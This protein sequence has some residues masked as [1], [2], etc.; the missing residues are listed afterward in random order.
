MQPTTIFHYGEDH[1]T[2]GIALGICQ[3]KING[4]LSEASRKK[5]KA[6][7]EI[8]E[9]IVAQ[10]APV[11]GINTGIGSLCTTMISE[12][13]TRLLQQNVLKSHSVGVGEAIPDE[14]AKLMLVLKVQALAKGFSGVA[15]AT[16]DRILWHIEKDVIP[17]VPSQGSVGASGDLAP[18]SHLFL[19][20]IGLGE[21][22][23]QGKVRPTAE[24]LQK[25]GLEAIELGPKE[26]L[27][28]ING[29]QFIAAFAVKVVQRLHNC[30]SHADLIGALMIEGLL[31]S[32]KPFVPELHQLRPYKG[33]ST[34]CG[35]DCSPFKRLRDNGFPRQLRAGAGPLLP[36]LYAPSPRRFAQ[37]LA[38]LKR[39]S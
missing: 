28:L 32:V 38:P 18:L 19:P 39:N 24:V 5:V 17:V 10:K 33:Q 21:V 3:G 13:K 9:K 31:G 12:E 36:A 20:L 37:R 16:L 30:L 11:Y 6:S 7:R 15:I 8:V 35:P 2:A 29:T 26:A 25:E 14:I 27:A 22:S 23:Y 4:Q 1:L 34:R